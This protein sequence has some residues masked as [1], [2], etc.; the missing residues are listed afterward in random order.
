MK[1]IALVAHVMS[2]LCSDL[3]RDCCPSC[4]VAR[5][6]MFQQASSRK[7]SIDSIMDLREQSTGTD[8]AT[9]TDKEPSGGRRFSA[10][11]KSKAMN[12]KKMA[13]HL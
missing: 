5:K 13:S 8:A 6:K 3:T 1:F 9:G 12:E 11:L 7:F 2:E 4:A 10:L